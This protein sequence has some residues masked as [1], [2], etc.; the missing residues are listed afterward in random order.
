MT[1]SHFGSIQHLGKGRYRI[2]VEGPCASDGRRTR[3]TKVIRGTRGDAEN[4]LAKMRLESG[5]YEESDITVSG[6]WDTFYAPTLDSLA[7]STASGYRYAY[8]GLVEPL[9]GNREMNTIKARDIEAGLAKI[10]KPGS[11]RN[12]YKLMRQMFNGAYRDELIAENPFQRRIRLKRVEAYE[13]EILLL[14]DIPAWLKAIRGSKWEPVLLCMLFGGL[15]REEACALRWSDFE[16]GVSACA[17]RIDKTLTSVRGKK[18]EG[19]TKTA[20]STRTVFIGGW[21]FSRLRE[22][23][24]IGPLC[25]NSKGEPTEPDRVSREYRKLMERSDAK[26]VPM[27]NL[28]NSYATI[29]QGLGASD[30]LIS[31]SLGHTELQTDY[32]HYFAANAPAHLANAAMLGD[33]VGRIISG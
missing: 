17:V 3:R 4:A 20:S 31:K 15:R 1:R 27:K 12:A 33:A 7:P 9:F 14:S 30:S 2:S 11:Q 32:A 13:P 25:P 21:P 8:D 23:A 19:R 18:V 26:Y 24:S 29:M 28:R 5:R 6:Y 22:L 16:W 10:E